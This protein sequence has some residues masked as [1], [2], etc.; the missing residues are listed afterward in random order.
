MKQRLLPALALI[1]LVAA[2]SR[3]FGSNI[4]TEDKGFGPQD[5]QAR[6]QGLMSAAN[7]GLIL[8]GNNGADN[9]AYLT[10]AENRQ[11][12]MILI[13]PGLAG[14]DSSGEAPQSTLFLPPKSPRWGVWDDPELSPGEEASRLS[15]IPRTS[16]LK[17]FYAALVKLSPLAKTIYVCQNADGGAPSD[18]GTDVLETVKRILPDAKIKNLSPVLDDL[19]WSKS[20]HDIE[21]MKMA[22]RVTAEAFMEA[23]RVTKPGLYEYEL[24]GLVSYIFRKDGSSGPA[25]LI[26]GSGPNSCV[27]HHMSNDRRM[28][29]GELVV[30]DIGTLYHTLSTDLTRTLPVSGK[31]TAEQKKVYAVVLEAQKKALS[32]VKPGATLADVHKAAFEVIDKAG[33]GKYFIHGTS[34][35]LNGGSGFKA[36]EPPPPAGVRT[37]Q[38]RASFYMGATNPLRPGCM[39][40]IE[41]GIYIPEKNLGIRI[42]DDILVTDTGYEIL[43]KDAPKEIADIE[44]LMAM[45]PVVITGR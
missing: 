36:G 24:D 39:F 10:G 3:S 9:L 16:E 34:H 2:L 17:D 14:K 29:E 28:N 6:C 30:L 27:L 15:G 40:T 11:A 44:R 1:V 19:R 7:D 18:L 13:P 8:A 4:F 41:P 45:K 37:E 21:V 25:F 26:V 32:V 23:A 31:F 38:Q 12:R 22:C 43:T 33:Y 5:F 42:E 20:A 35:S